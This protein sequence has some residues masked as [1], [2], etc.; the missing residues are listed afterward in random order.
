MGLKG[1]NRSYQQ[2]ANPQNNS[3][4]DTDIAIFIG[5]PKFAVGSSSNNKI[6]HM[7]KGKYD[8]LFIY[9]NGNNNTINGAK[10]QM[11]E[12]DSD[13]GLLDTLIAGYEI[14]VDQA[15]GSFV[16]EDK[17]SFIKDRTFGL[18]YH[19]GNNTSILKGQALGVFFD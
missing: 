15:T 17:Y 16:N 10:F 18:Q 14:V 5:R 7:Y 9:V 13:N 3:F 12:S 6:Y 4:A 11:I 2:Y 1:R 19:H 8:R